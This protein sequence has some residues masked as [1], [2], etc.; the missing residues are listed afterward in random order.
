MLKYVTFYMKYA[1]AK[2]AG[3]VSVLFTTVTMA[4]F[5]SQHIVNKYLLIQ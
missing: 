5:H 2:R 1:I 4:T 3:A